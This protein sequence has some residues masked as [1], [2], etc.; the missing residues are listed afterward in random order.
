[1]ESKKNEDTQKM[2]DI[3]ADNKEWA[4]ATIK[5]IMPEDKKLKVTHSAIPNWKWPE[6]TMKFV[7]D[8]SLDFSQFKENMKMEIEITKNKGNKYI[9]TDVR[10]PEKKDVLLKEWASATVKE[11]MQE[12]NKLKV[13][14]SAIPNWKWPEMTMK[15][16]VDD[17]LDFT[18]F[19]ENMKIEIEISRTKD[20][21]YIIS[22]VR[23]PA[24][25]K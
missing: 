16:V 21:K 7:V 23:L 13:T 12:D 17:S 24:E 1:M 19:K 2:A 8:D 20:N 5:E 18:Q 6:M 15:F 4:N 3:K 9:I 14:H 11:I 25:K 22:D 10:M